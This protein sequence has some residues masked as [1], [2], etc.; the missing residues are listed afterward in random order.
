MTQN[1]DTHA[2]KP[3]LYA[4]LVAAGCKVDSHE[5]DLYVEAT[6]KARA[7]IRAHGSI[8]IPFTNQAPDGPGGTWLE[9][10]FAYAPFWEKTIR[11]GGKEPIKG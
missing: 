8:G 7:I 4:D 6:P 11:D 9:I 1:V 10:P 2:E 3:T 5:S